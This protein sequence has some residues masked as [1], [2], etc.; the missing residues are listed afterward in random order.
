MFNLGVIISPV[1]ENKLAN[2][3]NTNQL[4]NNILKEKALTTN[5]FFVI[6]VAQKLI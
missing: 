3:I 2:V 4:T 6:H 1:K 5:Q